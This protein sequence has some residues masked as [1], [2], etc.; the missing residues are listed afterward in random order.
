MVEISFFHW[1]RFRSDITANYFLC[2]SFSDTLERIFPLLHP[3][4]LIR[5]AWF[6]V[7]ENECFSDQ[8]HDLEDF[9]QLL[10]WIECFTYSLFVLRNKSNGHAEEFKDKNSFG[11]NKVHWTFKQIMDSF[12]PVGFWS[13]VFVSTS[14]IRSE[15]SA[16]VITFKNEFGPFPD[17]LYLLIISVNYNGTRRQ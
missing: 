5:Y 15:I 13:F 9:T 7:E 14:C 16:W 11:W 1:F 3:A 2:F 12:H 10:H 4:P 8:C 17:R 6:I